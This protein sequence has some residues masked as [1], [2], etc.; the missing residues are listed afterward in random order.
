VLVELARL[1]N[2]HYE[3]A[4]GLALAQ[5]TVDSELSEPAGAVHPQ[6]DGLRSNMIS[7]HQNA[8]LTSSAGVNRVSEDVF[9]FYCV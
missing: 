7:T 1:K 4:F 5:F 9:Q 3:S 8:I 6:I 2:K